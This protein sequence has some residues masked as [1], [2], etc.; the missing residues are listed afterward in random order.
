MPLT[1]EEIARDAVAAA[2]A[3]VGITSVHL[4]V[5]ARDA[6]GDPTW[7]RETY[8]RIVGGVRELRPQVVI[9]V[10]TSGRTW[11]ELERRADVLA[12][13]GDLKPDLASLTLSSLNF[14]HPGVSKHRR[15][16][17]AAWPGSCS[18]AGIV[19][20]LEI[21]DLGMLNVAARAASRTGCCRARSS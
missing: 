5:H 17:C 18:S 14:L 2:A 16:S 3:V 4:R 6:A 7:E 9:N 11:F 10:S 1:P 20:E 13:D 12:L 19:P 21:F 15:T 8:A